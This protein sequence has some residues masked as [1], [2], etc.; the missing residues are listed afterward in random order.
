[1][2]NEESN[3][4]L[5]LSL[6]QSLHRP[7]VRSSRH[8]VSEMLADDFM[9]FGSSGRVYDKAV[10]V[11]AL[12]SEPGSETMP[13]PTVSNFSVKLISADAAL[14]TYKSTRPPTATT[15]ARQTL[16]SS[17]WKMTGGRWK[18]LFHQGTPIPSE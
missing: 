9:E 7:D 4:N 15:E 17:I 5:F 13:L 14:V 11:A 10:T 8:V 6:E 2:S 1:M 18:M 3:V 12:A 16:R